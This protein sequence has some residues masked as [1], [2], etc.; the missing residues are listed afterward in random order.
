MYHPFSSTDTIKTA[1]FLVRKNFSLISIYSLI[2]F[3][4]VIASFSIIF[5]Y[6]R[7]DL[8]SISISGIIFIVMLSFI[9]L[10]F[11]K[12][13]FQLIDKEY[14]DFDFSDIVPSGKMIY[15]Y[16]LL[17]LLIYTASFFI[18]HS[19]EKKMEDGWIKYISGIFIGGFLQFFLIFY[20]PICACFIVDDGSGPFESV[21]QSFKLIKGNFLRYFLLFIVIEGLVFIGF[22]T[23][24]GLLFA[25]PFSYIILVVAYRKLVYSHQDVD[26][27]LAETK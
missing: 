6:F 24:I 18:E 13:I 4:I 14:Y 21:V 10:G 20:F 7:H 23:L 2:G 27:D 16:L 26:D 15:G 8:L 25:V 19:F 5:F 12:L 9:I 22:F 3:T 11:I 17:F 1:W